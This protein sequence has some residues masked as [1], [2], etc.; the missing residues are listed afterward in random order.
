MRKALRKKIIGVSIMKKITMILLV[1][2][3][4]AT[5]LF[6]NGMRENAPRAEEPGFGRIS[7]EA[8]TL[9]GIIEVTDDAVLL[10]ADEESYALSMQRGAL[11][12]VEQYDAVVAEI[13]GLL[14]DCDVCDY[15]GH[16]MVYSAV[17]EGEEVAAG[18]YYGAGRMGYSR[19]DDKGFGNFRD[20]GVA[21]RAQQNWQDADDY[22]G[23][24][25]NAGGR[26]SGGRH[27]M[28]RNTMMRGNAD[29]GRGGFG[30]RQ[31]L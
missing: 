31:V 30:A 11:L 10:N 20:A 13:T 21:G 18:D 5:A 23:S 14:T 1:L 16:I 7:G 12:D 28:D 2:M 19:M 24:R 25:G 6:A 4:A 9:E 17:V 29:T 3:V 26:S 8:V 27:P 15:D 22:R